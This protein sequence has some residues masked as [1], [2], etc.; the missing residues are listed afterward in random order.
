MSRSPPDKSRV[1][2]HRGLRVT[3]TKSKGNKDSGAISKKNEVMYLAKDG[4]VRGGQRTEYR[5]KSKS[6]DR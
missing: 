3:I 1:N 6:F 4:A 5:Q 2:G